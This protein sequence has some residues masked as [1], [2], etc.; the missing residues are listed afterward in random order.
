MSDK[1]MLETKVVAVLLASYYDI[2]RVKIMDSVPKAIVLKLVA[3][4]KQQMLETIIG[5][6]YRPE[7]VDDLLSETEETVKQRK[8]LKEAISLMH[9]ALSSIQSLEKT[10]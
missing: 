7:I 8:E 10:V 3:T 9:E 2:I 5:Q 4:M 1:E 6:L